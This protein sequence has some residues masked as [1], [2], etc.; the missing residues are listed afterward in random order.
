MSS[1]PLTPEEINHLEQLHSLANDEHFYELLGLSHIATFDQIR[2]A[3]HSIS[4]QWH[5]DRFFR[6][7][8]G[9][10]QEIIEF[11]FM[12]ITKAYRTLSSPE[13]RL[14]Y[15]REHG[16]KSQSSDPNKTKEGGWHKHKRGRRRR[17]RTERSTSEKGSSGEK[18]LRGIR[19]QRREA[20]M[21]KIN[22]GIKEQH[23][24]AENFF[25]AGKKDLDEEKIQL[26]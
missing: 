21:N 19:S 20:F 4:R 15:D 24:R 10:H 17:P 16:H 26:I 11:L 14:D 23:Q 6:R 9:E 18:R 8:L 5:P 13:T 25:D 3:Y 12:Q 22:E 2:Q 1:N 7:D